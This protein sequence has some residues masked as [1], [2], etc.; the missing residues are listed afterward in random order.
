MNNPTNTPSD[1]SEQEAAL[2]RSVVDPGSEALQDLL[3][4]ASVS[5]WGIAGASRLR[6]LLVEAFE[7]PSDSEVDE[8]SEAA[9]KASEAVKKAEAAHAKAAEKLEQAK[10]GV[11]QANQKANHLKAKAGSKRRAMKDATISK[12]LT[13][14]QQG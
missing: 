12:I 5:S 6:Q 3:N 13:S 14:Y 8:A 7:A 4:L 9:E 2:L 1:L 10:L 11:I